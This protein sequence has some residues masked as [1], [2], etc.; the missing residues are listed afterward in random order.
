MADSYDDL[1]MQIDKWTKDLET[2]IRR[3]MPNVRSV[4]HDL[5]KETL[6]RGGEFVV[7]VVHGFSPLT[8]RISVSPDAIFF[9]QPQSAASAIHKK[10]RQG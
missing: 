3:I 2:E 4:G 6:Q 8:H 9:M 7:E 1:Q 5:T 10:I